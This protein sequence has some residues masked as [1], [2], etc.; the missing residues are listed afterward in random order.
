MHGLWL[1][2]EVD[3]AIEPSKLVGPRFANV[4]VPVL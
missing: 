1:S 3:T 2:N 4:C